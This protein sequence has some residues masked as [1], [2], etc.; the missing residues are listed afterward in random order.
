MKLTAL[1][2]EYNP[3][4]NGHLYH[5]Q[6]SREITNP[7]GI[8]VIMSGHFVQRGTP[9]IFDKWTR[10]RMALA[11]GADLVIE[12]PTAYAISS[13]ENFAFGA[14]GI[15]NSLN[16]IDSIVFGSESSDIKSLKKLADFLYE[17]K[18]ISKL[19]QNTISQKNKN[20]QYSHTLSQNSIQ[21]LNQNL[22]QALKNKYDPKLH[23]LYNNTLNSELKKGLS[24]P[25]AREIALSSVFKD[26]CLDFI[27]ISNSNDILAVEYIKSINLLNNDINI[28]SIKRSSSDYNS[29]DISQNISSATAI[30]NLIQKND[31]Y[32]NAFEK[33]KHT[34]PYAIHEIYKNAIPVKEEALFNYVIYKIW[35]ETHSNLSLIEGMSEGLEHRIIK[36]SINCNNYNE[37]IENIKTK[38]Y[39]RTRI[40]RT[41][42]S[43]L[44]NI[45][46]EFA[47]NIYSSTEYLYA[48]ILGA[49]QNGRNIIKSLKKVSSIPIITNVNKI[50]PS[51]T[52]MNE[53]LELDSRA[54][55]IYSI[56]KNDI[57]KGIDKRHQPI[58]IDT[59]FK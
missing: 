18:L 4:H 9:A 48:R 49:N 53:L 41:L 19:E 55:D 57:N 31:N 37:L 1:I 15:I 8:I 36:N 17:N 10:T 39:T 32:I 44:L 46:S 59:N 42:L 2:T 22:T 58:L 29:N 21:T 6:K 50:K 25:K 47:N 26:D 40:Q 12:L 3:F 5:I 52:M 51:S 27:D 16:G 11:M 24:Y 14:I 7:D 38:R 54:S 45:Q 20:P 35:S 33:I 30:R 23:L 34:M 56:L 13:A 43:M 28:H